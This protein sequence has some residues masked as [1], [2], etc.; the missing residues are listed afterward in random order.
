M[1]D[2]NGNT[3]I[4]EVPL[5]IRGFIIDVDENWLYLGDNLDG[6]TKTI[7]IIPGM[8]IE[9][10]KEHSEFDDILEEMIIPEKGGGN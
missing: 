8:I 7:R 3:S 10:I 4:E 5:A 1:S 2:A 9:I 6:I